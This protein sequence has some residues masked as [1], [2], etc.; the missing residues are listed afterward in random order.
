M[1][2]FSRRI[3]GWSRDSKAGAT[4][5]VDALDMAIRNRRPQAG[6]IVHADREAQGGFNRWSQHRRVRAT[7][8]GR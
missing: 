5:V 3:V 6:G 1:D 2:A 7:I 4:L 8:D